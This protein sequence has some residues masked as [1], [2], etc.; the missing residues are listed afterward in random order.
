MWRCLGAGRSHATSVSAG[1]NGFPGS[2]SIHV[3]PRTTLTYEVKTRIC[4]RSEDLQLLRM[5]VR[6]KAQL[7]RCE[8]G[9]SESGVNLSGELVSLRDGDPA[10]TSDEHHAYYHEGWSVRASRFS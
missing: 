10:R 1:C 8:K 5:I 6:S 2:G 9:S 7:S 4:L 3:G